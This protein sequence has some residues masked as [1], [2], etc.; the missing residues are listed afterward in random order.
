MKEA[1]QPVVCSVE[2]ASD[3]LRNMRRPDQPMPCND[4][5]DLHI[6]IS[7]PER[8]WLGESEVSALGCR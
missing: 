2:R 1:H 4:A 6:V 7:E 3:K 8:R 5:H